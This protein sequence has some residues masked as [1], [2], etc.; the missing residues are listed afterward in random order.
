[1]EK[2]LTRYST[3]LQ[4]IVQCPK[5]KASSKTNN[6]KNAKKATLRV[7]FLPM[8]AVGPT[9]YNSIAMS[10]VGYTTYSIRHQP[11]LS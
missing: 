2:F 3:D 7:T 6:P 4:L 8:C 10:V 11:T 1:M 5:L 9:N